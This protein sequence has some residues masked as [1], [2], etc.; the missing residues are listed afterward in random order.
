MTAN[1]RIIIQSLIGQKT[2]PV[3]WDSAEKMLGVGAEYQLGV[4]VDHNVD[5]RTSEGGSCIFLHVW[6]DNQTG[7]SGCTAM[8]QTNIY[9]LV[10]WLDPAAQPVLVQLPIANYHQLQKTLQLPNF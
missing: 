5:P 3:D 7:T 2:A 1:P 4:V 6:K 9:R 10:G 8:L